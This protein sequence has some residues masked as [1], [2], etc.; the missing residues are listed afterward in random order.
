MLVPRGGRAVIGRYYPRVVIPRVASVGGAGVAIGSIIK[1]AKVLYN[2]NV[3]SKRVRSNGYSGNGRQNNQKRYKKSYT[4]KK[5]VYRKQRGNGGGGGKRTLAQR[6]NALSRIVSLNIGTRHYRRYGSATVA[7]AV[8]AVNYLNCVGIDDSYIQAALTTLK[9]FNPAVEE[10]LITV[11][12]NAGTFQKEIEIARVFTNC[13]CK[14]NYDIPIRVDMFL[15]I[16]KVDTSTSPYTAVESGLTDV[17]NYAVTT[18][19]LMPK[20]VPLFKDLYTVSRHIRKTLGPGQSC[21]MKYFG[22]SFMYDPSFVD[23]HGL[24]YVKAH[25]SHHFLIRVQGVVGHD[26]AVADE[27]GF[28]PAKVD[29]TTVRSMIIKYNAG[30]NIVTYDIAHTLDTPTNALHANVSYHPSK[31]VLTI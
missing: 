3:G 20:D 25:R 18:P 19:L 7:C 17:G 11:N 22:K 27:V 23:V 31:E 21:G 30:T 5:S 10:T 28:A 4:A 15:C 26:T 14:N 6:V 12:F 1:L 16:P 8:N 24:T 29:V 9:V 2:M 13:V